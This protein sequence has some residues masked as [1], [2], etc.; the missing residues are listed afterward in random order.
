VITREIIIEEDY[1]IFSWKF[2]MKIETK[3]QK[4]SQELEVYE[5]LSIANFKKINIFDGGYKVLSPESNYEVL[6]ETDISEE[7]NL[8]AA[9]NNVFL[10]E[11]KKGMLVIQDEKLNER[12]MDI[13][14][15]DINGEL[16]SLPLS[17][18]NSS[19]SAY[20][21]SILVVP[22]DNK[23]YIHI[24]SNYNEDVKININN[25]QYS[26]LIDFEDNNIISGKTNYSSTIEGKYDFETFE[27]ENESVDTKSIYMK[28]TGDTVIY[29]FNIRFNTHE[30][31][32][33]KTLNPGENILINS[34]K[35]KNMI[36]ICNDYKTTNEV[37]KYDFSIEIDIKNV[38]PM[39]ESSYFEIDDIIDFKYDN[40]KY[41]YYIIYLEVGSYKMNLSNENIVVIKYNL[42]C[43]MEDSKDQNDTYKILNI[44]EDNYYMFGFSEYSINDT[45]IVTRDMELN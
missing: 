29:Y 41:K 30:G 4:I 22:E 10:I 23:Y 7:I 25:Y 27:Y 1:F 17:Q 3:S 37:D 2:E 5:K 21:K 15:Y 35:G 13:K 18:Y 36:F 43:T 45:I 31:D 19:C 12:S 9:R 20:L 6:E 8:E 38:S 28:N 39:F 34:P 14:I 11:A 33:V 26:S 40:L 32:E 24:R 44:T 42:N 16:V